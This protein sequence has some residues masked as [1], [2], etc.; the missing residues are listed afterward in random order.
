MRPELITF[1]KKL[2]RYPV[3]GRRRSLRDVSRALAKAG[4]VTS[5]GKPFTATAIARMLEM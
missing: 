1:A 2:H 5:S 3:R 4:H